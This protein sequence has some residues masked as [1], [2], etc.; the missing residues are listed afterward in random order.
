MTDTPFGRPTSRPA[1]TR[2]RIQMIEASV[3]SPHA[4][5]R[6][7]CPSTSSAKIVMSTSKVAAFASLLQL[8]SAQVGRGRLGIACP[9]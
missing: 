8:Y 5:A 4:R 3:R 6:A 1:L 9:R 7:V 2:H